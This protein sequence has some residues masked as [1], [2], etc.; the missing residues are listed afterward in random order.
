MF[1]H[2]RLNIIKRY[3][4][5]ESTLSTTYSRQGEIIILF[6]KPSQLATVNIFYK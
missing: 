2:V 4:K 6:H 5:P 3:Y 1:F